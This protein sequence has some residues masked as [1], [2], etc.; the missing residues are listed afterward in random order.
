MREVAQALGV[1]RR[2]ACKWLARQRQDGGTGAEKLKL[3]YPP[4]TRRL[5]VA[6]IASLAVP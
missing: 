3:A 4:Q 2:I 5:L 1:R 6:R